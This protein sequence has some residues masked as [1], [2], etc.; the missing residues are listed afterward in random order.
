MSKP[1][2]RQRFAFQTFF[3]KK[4]IM[5]ADRKTKRNKKLKE[6]EGGDC[7]KKV[8]S[9]DQSFEKVKD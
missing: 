2:S 8:G 6:E 3:E 5:F 7:T 4:K 1:K 9:G